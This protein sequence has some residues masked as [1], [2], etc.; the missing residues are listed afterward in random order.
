MDWW[1]PDKVI[2]LGDL[3]DFYA[4]SDFSRDPERTLKLQNEIDE[5]IS[6]LTD[7]RKHAKKVKISFLNG[8][9]ELRLRKYLWRHAKELNGL[10]AL[11]LEELL[12]FGNFNINYSNK[13]IIR[14]KGILVKHGTT[15]RKWAGYSARGEFE[16][17]GMSG[18]SCHTHRLAK[19]HQTNEAGNFIWI[20]SGC[21][22]DFEHDYLND[23]MPNWQTGFSIGYFKNNSKKFILETVPIIKGKALYG[24]KEF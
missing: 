6:V 1:K 5:A 21:L 16:K 2:I 10:Q 3:V 4:I 14:Y 17:H 8:N 12:K 20:E 19:Y 22:C 23:E 11:K 15:V 9:H 13:G 24:G 7:I 18:I